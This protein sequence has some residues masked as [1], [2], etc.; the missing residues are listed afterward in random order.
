MYHA[1]SFT[2]EPEKTYAS[3]FSDADKEV[4]YHA[5]SQ[6]QPRPEASVSPKVRAQSQI[7]NQPTHW[8]ADPT[9][10]PVRSC[11]NKYSRTFIHPC[12]VPTSLPNAGL[13]E[14][15]KNTVR[16][17]PPT[18]QPTGF[19]DKQEPSALQGSDNTI[20]LLEDKPLLTDSKFDNLF[21]APVSIEQDKTSMDN[22]LRSTLNQPATSFVAIR[23]EGVRSS[24]GIDY[25]PYA[26]V[27]AGILEWDS[28][29]VLHTNIY[30]R[31]TLYALIQLH[32]RC[33][34][35]LIIVKTSCIFGNDSVHFRKIRT[36]C[37]QIFE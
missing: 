19:E 34:V 2:E 13:L 32:G 16:L 7:V 4:L 9:H 31:L 35:Y 36:L 27:T 3:D 37:R 11:K 12:T 17:E 1:Q 26:P 25:V 30:L 10:V 15:P 5:Q 8:C 14:T 18:L 33:A 23:Q 28:S 29:Q 24:S 22:V 21:F 20:I 6:E